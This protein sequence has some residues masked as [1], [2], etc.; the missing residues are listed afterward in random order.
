[1]GLFAARGSISEEQTDIL[2][3]NAYTRVERIVSGG[4]V[5]PKG[6]WYQQDEDEWVAVLQG[7][8]RIQYENGTETIL[9]KGDSLLLKADQRHRV[10]YTSKDPCCIWLCVFS[11]TEDETYDK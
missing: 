8:G 3:Q 5:S 9:R 10:S 11:K 7:E 1:M 4:Q 2:Y 6:Y